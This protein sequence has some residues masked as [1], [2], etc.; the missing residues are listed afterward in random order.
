MLPYPSGALHMGHVRTTPS[1]TL[2][3]YMDERLQRP[4]S[5]GLGFLRL[6][7]ENAAIQ[8]NTPPR[9]WTLRNIAAMKTQMGRLGF[10]RLVARGDDLSA[11]FYKWNQWFFIKFFEKGL[12]YRKRAGLT[13][14]R[15][16]LRFWPMSK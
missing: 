9:E 3:R 16:A 11:R 6:A 12:A 14:V 13:G 2:A 4:S 15:S 7:R 8:N 1:E 10:L 5:H